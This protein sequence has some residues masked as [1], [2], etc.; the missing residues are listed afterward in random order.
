MK[1]LVSKGTEWKV[2]RK[3]SSAKFGSKPWSLVDVVIYG[4][5]FIALF[6]DS[7]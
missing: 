1:E 6:V 4:V 7:S 5:R 3:I 2:L